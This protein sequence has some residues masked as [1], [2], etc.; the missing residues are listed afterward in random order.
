MGGFFGLF[1]YNKEGPG[2]YLNEPEKGPVKTF[3]AILGRKFWKIITVNLMYMLFSLPALILAFLAGMYIIPFIVPESLAPILENLMTGDIQQTAED[4]MESG[5]TELFVFFTFIFSML[6]V[7]LQLI[8]F[9]PVHAGITIIFRNYSREEH[10]F[11]WGDFKET[12]RKN[13]KQSSV[14]SIVSFILLIIMS[15]NYSFYA[16]GDM[17]DNPLIKGALTGFIILIGLMFVI[18]HM[19]I[20]PMM[21][22]FKVTLKQ[23]YKNSL[24]FAIAKLPKNVG[25]MLLN[26]FILAIIP[27]ILLFIP[28]SF[29]F[30]LFIFYYVFLGFGLSLLLT[31]FYVYRQLKRYMIDPAIIE[32]EENKE[33][34]E[35]IPEQ[36]KE[37]ALFKD[38]KPSDDD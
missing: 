3:M 17:I 25:I 27:I 36:E 23:L 33:S 6:L 10:A 18:M 15:V 5:A 30:I 37:K 35:E 14:T 19:Y 8:V 32:D 13:W 34:L 11:L 29:A 2:V 26:I 4:V 9:G 12:L 24:L 1:D 20:Y 28:F 31:N 38:T 21:I 16:N 22:T 7:G